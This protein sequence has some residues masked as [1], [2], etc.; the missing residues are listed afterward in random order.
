MW[1]PLYDMSDLSSPDAGINYTDWSDPE[2]FNGW[3][4]MDATRDPVIQQQIIDEMLHVMHDR[5]TWMLLYFQPDVYGVS[6]AIS[7]EP[8][9]DE[10]ISL[11]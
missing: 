10:T 3:K 6:N 7:W 1:S 4:K 11:N 9:A 8:R 5:G 2:F